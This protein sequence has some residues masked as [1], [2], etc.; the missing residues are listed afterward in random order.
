LQQLT[1]C[2]HSVTKSLFAGM[3]TVKGCSQALPFERHR[4]TW[5]L[6][7]A[8]AKGNEQALDSCPLDVAVDRIGPYGLERTTLF[9]VHMAM[10][11]LLR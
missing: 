11:A 5:S 10:I 6:N 1:G 2:L 3:R 7:Q 8:A 4:R 9:A